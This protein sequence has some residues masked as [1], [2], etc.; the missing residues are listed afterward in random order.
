MRVITALAALALTGCAASAGRVDIRSGGEPRS[1]QLVA[2]PAGN[3]APR[4]LLIALH[5]WLG[6]PGQMARMTGLSAAAT[7]LGFVV[8]YPKGDWRSWGID[9][10]SRRGAADAAFLADMVADVAGRVAIDPARISVAGISNGGFMAQALACSGRVR[11][12]GIA[13]VG[14]ALAASAAGACAAGVAVPFLLIAGTDDPIV[15]V[16][17]TGDGETRIL[18]ANETLAFWATANR[19]HGFDFAGAESREPGVTILRA[20]GRACRGGDTEGWLVQGGGHGWPGGDMFYPEFLVGHRTAAID[21][22]SVVLAF[23]ARQT[24]GR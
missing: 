17:G 9:A 19:C 18:P 21:A 1:Y 23:L 12:A 24:A 15:P 10:S 3:G 14:S 20:I 7:R 8:V 5:G 13:V 4:P 16:N 2:A 22:T 11:L 6:T